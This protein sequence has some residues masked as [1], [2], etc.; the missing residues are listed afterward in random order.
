[1]SYLVVRDLLSVPASPAGQ[2]ARELLV[3][4][5]DQEDH[6]DQRDLEDLSR[7]EIKWSGNQEAN[8]ILNPLSPNSAQNQFSP[9][10]IHRLS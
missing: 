10:D 5:R 4:P 7:L 6:R 2:F 8:L 9:N 3:V 1:M